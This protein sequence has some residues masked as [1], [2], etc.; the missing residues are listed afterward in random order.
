MWL[1]TDT[2]WVTL[3]YSS[4][5]FLSHSKA[6]YSRNSIATQRNLSS[7]PCDSAWTEYFCHLISCSLYLKVVKERTVGFQPQ[8]RDKT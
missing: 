7:A 4:G 5:S 8:L 6:S 2:L 1:R 3:R